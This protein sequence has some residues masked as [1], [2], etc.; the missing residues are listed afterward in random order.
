MNSDG[1]EPAH[2]G[3]VPAHQRLEAGDR[4]VL[5]PHDR[6]VEDRDL[7]ALERA[8][9]I[10]F[11]REPVVLARAHRRLE[12]LDAVAADALA[13]IHRKLGILQHVF[14]A[15]RRGRRRA[16]ARSRR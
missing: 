3:M 11:H 9:Q 5:Q 14:L 8:A 4:A 6:L 13:V 7:V 2:L 15:L 16:R 10:G 1:A 12:H